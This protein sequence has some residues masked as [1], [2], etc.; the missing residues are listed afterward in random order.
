MKEAK[1]TINYGRGFAWNLIFNFLTKITFAV[2]GIIIANQLG[3]GPV[4]IYA[5][6]TTIYNFADLMRDA[7]L[8]QAFYNDPEITPEKH[9]TYGRLAVTSGISFGLVMLA[10]AYPLALFYQL[11]DL[12]WCMAMAALAVTLNSLS[13]IPTAS[14]LK[15]GRFRDMGIIESAATF[16]SAVIALILVKTGFGL[17][18]LMMQLITRSAVIWAA[19]YKLAPVEIKDH[20][21]EAVR[22]IMRLC[23]QLVATDLLWM[24]YSIA[25]MLLVPKVLGNV[26]NGSYSWAKRLI[27]MPAELV[28]APLHRTVTI[29]VGHRTDDKLA[30][31]RAFSRSFSLALLL[32][33]PLYFTLAFFAPIVVHTILRPDFYPAAAVLPILCI[34]E[35]ARSMGAFAGTALVGGRYAQVPLIAWCLPYFVAGGMLYMNWGHLNLIN[36]AWSF[37]AGMLAVNVFVIASAF[38]LLSAWRLERRKLLKSAL[39]AAMTAAVAWGL[40][41]LPIPNWPSLITAAVAIPTLHLAIVGVFFGNHP[42]AFMS[43]SGLRKLR[44]AL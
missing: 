43:P 11:P 10:A 39:C 35:A 23:M 9:R 18:S 2:V 1:P 36:I 24:M 37:A 25:D 32:L 40:S 42:G 28:F 12:T 14:L 41:R 8:K 30:L 34:T 17:F 5:L 4:G 7:G 16:I 27:A 31:G 19:S 22:P 13:A 21:R 26:A 20:D 6:L 29:A 38:I 3:P 15:A 44:A 33:L